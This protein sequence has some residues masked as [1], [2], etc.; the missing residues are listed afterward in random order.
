MRRGKTFLSHHF[1]NS[2]K[3]DQNSPSVEKPNAFS[4]PLGES[5][6]GSENGF[7][8][9]LLLFLPPIHT[10]ETHKRIEREMEYRDRFL[11]PPLPSDIASQETSQCRASSSSSIQSS[12]RIPHIF[13]Y[14]GK[15][16]ESSLR[17][18]GEKFWDIMT[19]PY[20]GKAFRY[21]FYY[22]PY[23]PSLAVNSRGP[24]FS[25]SRT[26]KKLLGPLPT[27]RSHRKARR[28]ARQAYYYTLRY[29]PAMHEYP[30]P[31]VD[32]TAEGR[33]RDEDGMPPMATTHY[34][35]TSPFFFHP[36]V[37]ART[38]YLHTGTYREGNHR[39]SRTK[40]TL[41]GNNKRKKNY[42]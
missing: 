33:K 6:T 26:R 38:A 30:R 8:P 11:L 1:Y 31:T 24:V 22:V 34:T 3:R 28:E 36:V 25:P 7:P 5:Q 32:R 40:L 27:H 39:V 4:L 12:T 2:I 21:F 23:F 15:K 29:R 14:T 20:M 9:F 16:K 10:Q 35:P 41:A 37:H 13:F 18:P 17:R 42:Q 19:Q